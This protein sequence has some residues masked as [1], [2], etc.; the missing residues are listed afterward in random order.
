[1]KLQPIPPIPKDL[2]EVLDARFPERCPEPSWDDR[3]IWRE[4]GKRELIRFLKEEFRRQS[5]NILERTPS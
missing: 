1:V 2:L 4:V 3:T 5:D